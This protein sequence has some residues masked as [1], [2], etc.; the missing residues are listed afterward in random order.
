MR[1]FPQRVFEQS[2]GPGR[3]LFDEFGICSAGGCDECHAVL[4]FRFPVATL[5]HV[6]DQNA[7]GIA[8]RDASDIEHRYG[9]FARAKRCDVNHQPL[10][11]HTFFVEQHE[12]YLEYGKHI[13]CSILEHEVDAAP[14]GDVL[15]LVKLD[16]KFLALGVGGS[17]EY[18]PNSQATEKV[19]RALESA[20]AALP[21]RNVRCRSSPIHLRFPDQMA[22]TCGHPRAGWRAAGLQRMAN[23]TMLQKLSFLSADKKYRTQVRQ[24]AICAVASSPCHL[25]PTCRRRTVRA[26]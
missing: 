21:L 18:P 11:A 26:T 6:V 16:V 24:P 5:D 12:S 25:T 17:D 22:R 14:V 7:P 2:G 13:V 20:G 4:K 19:R 9:R 23:L 3:A 15:E 8:T 1:C 10:A